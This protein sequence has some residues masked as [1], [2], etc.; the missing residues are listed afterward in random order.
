MTRQLKLGLLIERAKR[1]LADAL[2]K[3]GEFEGRKKDLEKRLEDTSGITDEEFNQ[4]DAD[5]T[6][7]ENDVADIEKTVTDIESEIETMQTE[8]GDLTSKVDNLENPPE[9]RS[10]NKKGDK[11]MNTKTQAG[12]SIRE[13]LTPLVEREDVKG[14]L[15]KMRAYGGGDTRAITGAE[16]NVPDIILDPLRENIAK[17]SQLMKYVYF[18]PIK[19]NARQLVVGTIPEAVWTEM[20]G[21]LNELSFGFNMVEAD[22]YKIGG[23][24]PVPNSILQ[25]SDI[26]LLVEVTDMI[27][28]SI[29]YGI[30]KAVM[31]GVGKKMPLGIIPRLAAATEPRDFG[32]SAPAYTDLSTKNINHLSAADLAP[33][34]Y[35][36]EVVK[37]LSKAKSK[38]A[39]GGKFWAMNETTFGTLQQTLLSINAAGSIVTGANMTMPVIGGDIVI[40]DDGIMPD[41]VIAGGFGNLYLLVEREGSSIAKSEHVQFIQD[42]T[43]FKGTARYDGL[44][45]FGEGFAMFT[46]DTS[47]GPTSLDFAED[48]ANADTT[49]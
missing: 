6:A 2:A 23:F 43:V 4:L 48:T 13:R 9:D 18:K 30:D 33:T 24:I 28:K 34:A 41:N 20:T 14:F 26:N 22:G 11:E 16:L 44:P 12:V 7:L 27:G 42:N 21:T 39:S 32:K 29:G 1:K 47:N 40:L 45:V 17:Y 49:P 10:E 37:G 25:D 38:H 19:G 36:V 46:L 15:A 5:L 8:L 35:Y 31:Y 3:Q